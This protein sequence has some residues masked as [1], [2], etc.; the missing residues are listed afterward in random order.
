MLFSSF[1]ASSTIAGKD[2]D[3]IKEIINKDFATY[4][5]QAKVDID[6]T[7]IL[8]NKL[9]GKIIDIMQNELYEKGNPKLLAYYQLEL[10]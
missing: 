9:W 8:M 5:E 7:Q 6:H 3:S 2:K 1:S 4:P 10:E